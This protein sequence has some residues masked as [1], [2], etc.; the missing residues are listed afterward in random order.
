MPTYILPKHIAFSQSLASYI[1]YNL[2]DST[3]Q[4]LTL[5]QL[6]RLSTDSFDPDTDTDTAR[7]AGISST[8][9]Q[10]SPVQGDVFLRQEIVNFHQNLNCHSRIIDAA[11]AVTF[12]GAQEALSAIYHSVLSAGDEII[13]LTPSYPSLVNMAES[14]GVTVREIALCAENNW[15]VNIE[16][17]NQLVNEKTRLIV[18]NSP[19]NPTGSTID[20]NLANQILQLAQQYHCYLLSDDVSQASNY[21]SLALA[22]RYLDYPKS[23]VVGV[24][25]KS[26]G[27]AGV[28]IGWAIT[29]NNTLRHSLIAIKAVNSICC[30][31]I[32]EKLACLA[33]KSS[34]EILAL[35]NQIIL[36]NIA[37]FS[38]LIAR[39]PEKLSWQAPQAGILAL[40]EVKNITSITSWSQKLAKQSGIL[41]LPSELFGLKG[42]YFRL[43]LG[44][45]S[46]AKTLEVFE[47]FLL[48]N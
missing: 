43:G 47:R 30:S 27:L 7:I 16:D 35:N 17:F 37:L 40:V 3:A 2:S 41:A 46:F 14:I 36:D 25:S 19:H 26:L 9:L 34:K 12:C 6:C 39:H 10:Y 31:K 23:I 28:R 32:D 13:I 1:N 5:E 15:Q 44:Q 8:L 29:T 45:R 4:A 22:H 48:E 11:S 42:N 18:L 20:T 24:M 33:L 21:H 38:A